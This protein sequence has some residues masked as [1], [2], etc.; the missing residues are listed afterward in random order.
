[1][2][3]PARPRR[4]DDPPRAKSP[5][6]MQP[7]QPLQPLRKE[8]SQD[9]RAPAAPKERAISPTPA[10]LPYPTQQQ[11]ENLA[12][13]TLNAPILV[14]A[15]E[16]VRE[17][18]PAPSM[19]QQLASLETQQPLRNPLTVSTVSQSSVR[20]EKAVQWML[21]ALA[22]ASNKGFLLPSDASGED[23]AKFTDS[24]PSSDKDKRVLVQALLSVKQE[25]AK[26]KVGQFSVAG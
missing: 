8:S 11:Q 20:T 10:A 25:L 13:A 17:Q 24:G 19:Q 15:R 9:L 5:V 14:Q 7:V 26:A 1:M 23:L 22:T 3:A 21:A 4:E 6:T 2:Q 12:P 16:Q 18:A